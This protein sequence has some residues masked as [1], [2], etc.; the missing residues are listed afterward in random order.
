VEVA[1]GSDPNNPHSIPG[2]LALSGTGLLGTEDSAGVDTA[3]FHAG[4]AAFIN[5][6]NL[7][8]HVDTYNGAVADPDSYVGI[9]WVAPLTNSVASLQ[10]TMATFVDGGWFGPNNTGPGAGGTLT[11]IYLSEPG[12]QVSTDGG[13]TWTNVPHTSDYLTTFNGH[14]IGGGANPNPTFATAT[15][16]LPQPAVG[17]NAIRIIGA[18]GGTASGGFIGVSELMVY[19]FADSDHDGMDDNWERRYGLNVGINDASDDPDGDGLTN[20]QE[21][22]AGTNPKVA[23]TDSDGLNDGAEINTYHTNPN[24]ADTDVDGLTDGDE[25]NKYHT[26]PLIA[27][28]DGDLFP[29]GVEVLLGSDPNNPSSVPT[30]LALR[31]DATGILGTD[32]G[33]GTDTPLFNGSGA[34]INDNNLTTRVDTY[35]GG[36]TDPLSFVGIVWT[37]PVTNPVVNV[38]LTLATFVDGGWF[39]PNNSGPGPG[40]ALN[41]NYLTEPDLQT[42]ID[43]GLSWTAAAHTSDYTAVMSTHSIGGGANPNPDSATATFTLNTPATGINGIRL[44]GSEGGTASS[45]F[46]GVF[47][48]M[49]DTISP[50]VARAVTL[51]N[52]VASPGA[53]QFAFVSQNGVNHVVQYKNALTDAAWQTLLS[54]TGDGSQKSVTNTVTGPRRFYRVISQ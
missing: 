24:S 47:E 46:L 48:F 32:D 28:T 10:L 2:N 6:A 36:G 37:H 29:D 35:N 12:V 7:A 27:D 30:D 52:V 34:A 17:I 38:K 16:L 51:T 49:A 40:G 53:F 5:D 18:E 45:G 4:T 11:P 54:V 3:L 33:A 42:S 21:Y 15:F 1:A 44:I 31:S 41:T 25:V 19:A 23:D 43:G 13:T 9:V 20:L 39:G 22:L 26:N 14:G 8:T 50:V